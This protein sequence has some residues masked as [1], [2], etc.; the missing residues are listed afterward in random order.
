[1]IVTL[2]AVAL[3][4]QLANEDVIVVSVVQE[5]GSIE[6]QRNEEQWKSLFEYYF[7]AITAKAMIG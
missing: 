3:A 7:K 5:D 1:M 4:T 6:E 2:D